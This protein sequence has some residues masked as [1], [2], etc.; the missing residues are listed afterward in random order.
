MWQYDTIN[1]KFIPGTLPAEGTTDG[2]HFTRSWYEKWYGYLKT[3][4]VDPE[5]YR[6]GQGQAEGTE[7]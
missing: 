3:H 6:A 7:A 2:I 4:T 1:G 5:A